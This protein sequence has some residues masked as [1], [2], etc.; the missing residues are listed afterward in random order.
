MSISAK[1]H[2]DRGEFMLD[3]D[4]QVPSRGVTALFGPSGCGKST[5]LRAIAGLERHSHGELVVGDT[6]WQD[7]HVFVPP[8]L[9]PFGYVFQEASLF[10]HLSVL[11]NLEYGFKRVPDDQRRVSVEQAVQLLGEKLQIVGGFGKEAVYVAVGKDALKTLKQAIG[12]SS[13][14]K[15]VVPAAISVSLSKIANVAA[16][17]SEGPQKDIGS[18]EGRE[19]V[20]MGRT[21]SREQMAV[22]HLLADTTDIPSIPNG[23]VGMSRSVLRSAQK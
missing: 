13:E 23:V 12:N 1:F 10:A 8:H 9:R 7:E 18:G 20:K 19:G 17:L 4:L 21:M 22:W 15:A 2:I 11:R 14:P 3:V 5:L 6:T 16:E